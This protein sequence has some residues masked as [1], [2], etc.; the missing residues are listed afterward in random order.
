MGLLAVDFT[1][2]YVETYLY[3]G[4]ANEYAD[5]QL[6]VLVIFIYNCAAKSN[7]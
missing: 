1:W 3:N 7:P 2:A 5:K 6:S 4:R